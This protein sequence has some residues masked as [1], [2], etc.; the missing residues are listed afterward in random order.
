MQ[1]DQKKIQERLKE[2]MHLVLLEPLTL[3]LVKQGSNRNFIHKELAKFFKN[4]SLKNSRKEIFS[5]LEKFA[6]SL[7]VRIP[8]TLLDQLSRLENL[9]GLACEQ[10]L[11]FIN[12]EITP[13]EHLQF[14]LPSMETASI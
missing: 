12:H 2:H 6:K 8:Q 11:S 4:E 10:V 13:L 9:I 7:N 1:I 3:E 14:S 5:E